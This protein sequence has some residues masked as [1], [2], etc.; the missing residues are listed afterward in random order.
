MASAVRSRAKVV[1]A[2]RAR[3][4]VDGAA[5]SRRWTR[6]SLLLL[7]VLVAVLAFASAFVVRQI[8]VLGDKR[9]VKQAA[10]LYASG[11]DVLVE[12]LNQETA[13]RGY[14]IS[15]DPATLQPYQ[16]GR[17]YE[18]LE[19][20][21]IAKNPTHDPKLP[22]LLAAVKS[23]VDVL[24]RYYA[25]QVALVRSGPAGQ[26]TA[27]A[28]VLQGKAHFDRF[29]QA[30]AALEAEAVKIF[31]GARNKQHHTYL[32]ALIFLICAGV[33]VIAI[34]LALLL[35]IPKR[36]YTLYRGEQEARRAAEE[37]AD[38]ARAL[39]HVGEAVVLLDEGGVVRSWN[40]AAAAFFGLSPD[41]VLGRPAGIVVP[42]L[43]AL[44]A[45]AKDVGAAV[46]VQLAGRS[47]W[48]AVAESQFAD[49]CV[50]VLRDVTE[51]RELERV[52]SEF[53]ATAA[54]ELRTPLAAVY[55]AVR[56]LRRTDKEITPDVQEAFLAMIETESE[57][58]RIITDQLLVTAQLDTSLLE[59]VPE[60]IDAGAL[61]RD[62]IESVAVGLPG[63][64]Q[65]EYEGPERPVQVLADAGR[66]R[67]VL[68]NLV[69]NAVKYSP[70]G[71]RIALRVDSSNG[72]GTIA[73]VDEGLGIPAHEQERIFEKFY[74]LDPAMTRGIGGSG[75]GLHISRE[76]VAVMGGTV[77]VRSQPGHGSTFV[78]SLPLA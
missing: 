26:R 3:R 49:G 15:G 21:I 75:L 68:S 28:S 71:G 4:E 62:L 17:K 56:T 46:S 58:L 60:P 33:L 73:V 51:D 42:E 24:E 7:I 10:P 36:I 77:T 38:A 65:L 63:G 52:R 47:R 30:S 44:R 45:S 69:D 43:A 40:P 29:R 34:A 8:Y 16:Q 27:A 61:C 35:S 72:N 76:L 31:L 70:T 39:T 55:G 41:D 54:H 18:A 66:L 12:M 50:I 67:Q 9:Y 78:V 1:T 53:V 25:H 22:A 2:A 19:L 48:I 37:G 5:L 20:G 32:V 64:M 11:Q 23:Q 59:A 14:V 6:L 57:R 74:R 13:V